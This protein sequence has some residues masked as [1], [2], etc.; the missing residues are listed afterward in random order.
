MSVANDILAY[1]LI[2]LIKINSLSIYGDLHNKKKIQIHNKSIT[3]EFK[4]VGYVL[5]ISFF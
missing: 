3:I 2:N 1:K 4:I 5:V